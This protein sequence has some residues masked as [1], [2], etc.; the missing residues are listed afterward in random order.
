ME[1][2]SYTRIII[3]ES[4]PLCNTMMTY[5]YIVEL[6]ILPLPGGRVDEAKELVGG[7]GFRVEVHPHGFLSHEGIAPVEGAQ[8]LAL[9]G[10]G[11]ADDED[12]VSDVTQLLQLNHFQH[13]VVLSLQPQPLHRQQTLILGACALSLCTC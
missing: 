13:K 12:G 9:A 8:D 3:H 5:R 11:I 7:D 4:V 1:F 6:T 10:A 2:Y